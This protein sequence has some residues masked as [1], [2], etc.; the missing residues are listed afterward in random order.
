MQ[1][2]IALEDA[3]LKLRAKSSDG[4]SRYEFLFKCDVGSLEEFEKKLRAVI[5][6]F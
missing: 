4:A 3:K 5:A 2:T 6:S 1:Q